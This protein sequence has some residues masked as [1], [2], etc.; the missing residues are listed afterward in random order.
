MNEDTIKSYIAEI[1][2]PFIA[3]KSRNGFKLIEEILFSFNTK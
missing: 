1:N 3:S 2:A